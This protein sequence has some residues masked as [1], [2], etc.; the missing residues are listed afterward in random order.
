MPTSMVLL[1]DSCTAASSAASVSSRS[2]T[3]FA[4]L[5]KMSP[6]GVSATPDGVR[7]YS[8]TP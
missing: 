7:S 1:N 2:D 4:N 6:A 5:V 3:F 8:F